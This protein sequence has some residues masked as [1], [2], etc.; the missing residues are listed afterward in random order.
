MRYST[1]FL[2]LFLGLTATAVVSAPATVEAA[3]FDYSKVKNWSVRPIASNNVLNFSGELSRNEGYITALNLDPNALDN[4]HENISINGLGFAGYYTTGRQ[5]GPDPNSTRTA[6]LEGTNGFSNFFNY[7]N[8]NNIPVSSIG[9]N[10]DQKEGLD[11]TR[12]WNLGEDKLGQDWFASTDSPVEERIYRANPDDVK[13]Y[14]SYGTTQLVDLGYSDIFF[15]ADNG[16]NPDFNDNF[17]VSVTAPVPVSKVAGLD[18]LA[19]GLANAFLK[20]VAEAGGSVQWISED[21]SLEAEFYDFN[22]YQINTV[23]GVPIELRAVRAESQP[24][25]EPTSILAIIM[26]GGL[27]TVMRFKQK[28][29]EQQQ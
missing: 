22:G 10:L 1:L 27:G 21:P 13:I 18:S 23:G 25:P 16:P 20:D 14:L 26:F 2:S 28:R 29:N 9:F 6:S 19:S 15:V 7:L 8:S 12:G 3:S 5:G 11:F 4:G 24:V 17:N